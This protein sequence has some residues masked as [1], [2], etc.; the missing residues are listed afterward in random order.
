MQHFVLKA[1]LTH[2]IRV[3]QM[4]MQAL[5][6]STG[7]IWLGG[8]HAAFFTQQ[9]TTFQTF[10]HSMPRCDIKTAQLALDAA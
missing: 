4:P 1:L 2:G 8:L 6:D 7:T 10:Y 9:H 5:S 3:C